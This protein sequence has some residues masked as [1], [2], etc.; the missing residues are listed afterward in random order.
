MPSCTFTLK[1]FFPQIRCHDF[2]WSLMEPEIMHSSI[3]LRLFCISLLQMQATIPGL[4]LFLLC[5]WCPLPLKYKV[6][7][8]GGPWCFKGGEI[9]C[10]VQTGVFFYLYSICCLPLSFLVLWLQESEVSASVAP[11]FLL[12]VSSVLKTTWRFVYACLA[13]VSF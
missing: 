2:S 3:F 11:L 12:F 10:Y 6:T 8:L 5:F 9:I 4:D 7:K 13:S 1:A